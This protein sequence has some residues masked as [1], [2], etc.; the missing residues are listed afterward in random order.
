MS[1]VTFCN[2]RLKISVEKKKSEGS[3]FYWILTPSISVYCTSMVS[4]TLDSLYS[5]AT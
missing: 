4:R 1:N 2:L 3:R 5:Y